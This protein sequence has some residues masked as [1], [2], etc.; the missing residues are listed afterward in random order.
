MGPN[1]A[2]KSTLVAILATL[3]R[4]TAGE[5]NYGEVA[6]PDAR[7]YL[8][9]RIGLVAHAPLLYR[10]LSARENLHFFGRLYGVPDLRNAVAEQ[11]RALDLDEFLDRPVRDLSRGM[12]QRVALARALVSDPQLLLLDEPFTG[13]DQRAV[14][15]LRERLTAAREAG[16]I[17]IAV[18]H[19]VDSVHQLCDQLLVFERGRVVKAHRERDL[20]AGALREA[21]REALA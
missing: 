6:F 12:T 1:G 14:S 16:K 19:D 2:G 21:Y 20:T 18:T 4:P 17:I 10:E 15:M 5:I 3:S 9:H 7:L 13:L 8:R 11:S